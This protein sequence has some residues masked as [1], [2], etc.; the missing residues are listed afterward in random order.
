MIRSIPLHFIY[1][2]V[3]WREAK[4][5]VG[6]IKNMQQAADIPTASPDLQI[7]ACLQ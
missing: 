5:C 4:N 2:F 3:V 1:A 6:L 7:V